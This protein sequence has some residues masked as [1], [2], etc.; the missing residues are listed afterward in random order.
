MQ[1]YI[2]SIY[3]KK[4]EKECFVTMRNENEFWLFYK[5]ESYWKSLVVHHT[6]PATSLTLANISE[7]HFSRLSGNFPLKSTILLLCGVFL[8]ST[9][10][11]TLTVVSSQLFQSEVLFNFNIRNKPR[12][13]GT[14]TQTTSILWM[15]TITNCSV[16]MNRNKGR[17]SYSI[18]FP[19][20][21]NLQGLSMYLN[22]SPLTW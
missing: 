8:S 13:K 17:F 18:R 21:V 20:R 10:Y 12:T 16:W 22:S 9:Q 6:V 2:F 14:L 1:L 4:K 15:T 3:L 5:P 19:S 7:Y 11:F